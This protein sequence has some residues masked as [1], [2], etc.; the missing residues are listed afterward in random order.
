MPHSFFPVYFVL[1]GFLSKNSICL[2]PV[3]ILLFPAFIVMGRFV[4]QNADAQFGGKR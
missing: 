2:G 4:S 3:E 1:Y